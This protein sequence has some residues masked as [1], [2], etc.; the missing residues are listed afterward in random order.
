M[1]GGPSARAASFRARCP[2][3]RPASRYS[4]R[5]S[6]CRLAARGAFFPSDADIV[7]W[8]PA[9]KKILKDEDEF[10]NA[11]YSS[12]AG[13][14]VTGFPKTTIRR[15]EVVYDDGKIVGKAGSG[16]FIPGGK[17]QRPALRPLSD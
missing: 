13:M 2:H 4:A 16:R 8:D 7:I 3:E 11:K 17:F 15:G 12:Y 10:S 1:G 14:D 6:A 5:Q 9:M